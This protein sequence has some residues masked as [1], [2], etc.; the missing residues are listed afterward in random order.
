MLAVCL[1]SWERHV[2]WPLDLR[3]FWQVYVRSLWLLHFTLL[4]WL[5][6]TGRPAT[7]GHVGPMTLEFLM[8]SSGL[9][10]RIVGISYAWKYFTMVWSNRWELDEFVP[11]KLAS[12]G[13][14]KAAPR[15]DVSLWCGQ[16]AS[17]TLFAGNSCLVWDELYIQLFRHIIA[18]II[19][20]IYIYT[21][22]VES[23]I[24]CQLCITQ[25]VDYVG[26]PS[27]SK[28]HLVLRHQSCRLVLDC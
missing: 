14:P 11:K 28:Q 20:N 24:Q 25:M 3:S 2:V 27:F 21:W 19:Y 7:V 9:D 4:R 18:Y 26:D 15:T 10:L 6:P 1:L 8:N 12:S 22:Y 23:S 13:H 5:R 16:F 17:S